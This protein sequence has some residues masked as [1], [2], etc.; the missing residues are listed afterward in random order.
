M[1]PLLWKGTG[2]TIDIISQMLTGKFPPIPHVYF[3]TVDI[4]DL[5]DAHFAAL[6][7]GK[8]CELYA[9][10]DKTFSLQDLGLMIYNEYKPKGYKPRRSKMAK[11]LCWIGSLID[12]DAKAFYEQ[13]GVRCHVS[14][15]KSIRELGVSYTN[16]ET[17]IFEMCDSLIKLG[18]VP[19]KTK[20]K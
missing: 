5:A 11:C 10:C 3:T 8:N 20:K 4:R 18:I 1:G 15:R 12:K 17:A 6:E 19:D 14:N 13:W 9:A 16:S 7:K 2:S